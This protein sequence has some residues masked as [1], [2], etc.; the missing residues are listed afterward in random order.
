MQKSAFL[1]FIVVQGSPHT[2]LL[3]AQGG[4]SSSPVVDESTGTVVGIHTNGECLLLGVNNIKGK[5]IYHEMLACVAY[6][7]LS[8]KV[9]TGRPST[10][11][12]MSKPS[13][14]NPTSKPLSQPMTQRPSTG[15]LTL[16]PLSGP[17][18]RKLSS[19]QPPMQLPTS[20]ML[21]SRPPVVMLITQRPMPY[22]MLRLI[23]CRLTGLPIL[24]PILMCGERPSDKD[25][26]FTYC[27]CINQNGI[28]FNVAANVIAN[29]SINS[30]EV[31]V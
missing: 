17:T 3:V 14:R 20:S 28:M 2:L 13:P 27:Q 11:C 30:L 21:S 22:P 19:M 26:S 31:S 10:Q 6:L 9:P 5:T 1:L 25:W 23:T 18:T 7:K 29:I 24:L 4:N 8:S 16:K 12:P 15:S